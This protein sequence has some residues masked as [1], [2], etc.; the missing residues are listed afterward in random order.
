MWLT[1]YFYWM[2]L[3]HMAFPSPGTMYKGKIAQSIAPKAW[4]GNG[5]LATLTLRASEARAEATVPPP[6][7]QGP[8]ALPKGSPTLLESR[9]VHCQPRDQL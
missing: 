2:V 4:P 8:G 3:T 1:F 6:S 7:I 9:R 5:S